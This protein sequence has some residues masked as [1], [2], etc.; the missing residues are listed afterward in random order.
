MDRDYLMRRARECRR[1]AGRANDMAVRETHLRF[2]RQYEDEA[3]RTGEPQRHQPVA[4]PFNAATF[5]G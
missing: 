2:A 4:S 1:A 3:E 5:G